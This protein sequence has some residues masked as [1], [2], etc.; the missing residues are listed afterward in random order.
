VWSANVRTIAF[1]FVGQL[2]DDCQSGND[3]GQF[4][5]CRNRQIVKQALG[6]SHKPTDD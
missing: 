1:R 4:M 3:V 5:F 2:S 6:I